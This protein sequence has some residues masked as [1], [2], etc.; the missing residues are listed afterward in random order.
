MSIDDGT[1]TM[2]NERHGSGTVC[3]T[4]T[5]LQWISTISTAFLMLARGTAIHKSFLVPL[6]ALQAPESIVSWIKGEYG[7]WTAFLALL[8]CL[9]FFIPGVLELP[10]ITLLLIIACP[11]QVTGLRGTEEGITLSLV[12]AVYLA[13]QYFARA[14]SLGK[15]I[16]QGSILATLAV[17]CIVAVPCLLF[18]SF[19]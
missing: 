6:F 1:K 7:I 4:P 12:I 2:M 3:L 5:N 8:V 17:I 13:F 14:G 18:I 15:A 16:D 10:L 11:S 9:F 19:L